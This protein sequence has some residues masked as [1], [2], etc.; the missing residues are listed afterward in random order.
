[1]QDTADEVVLPGQ[2]HIHALFLPSQRIVGMLCEAAGTH[3]NKRHAVIVQV[4][5]EEIFCT[6]KPNQAESEGAFNSK[7]D[8]NRASK[9]SMSSFSLARASL[10]CCEGQRN[11][12]QCNAVSTA[13]S[14]LKARVSFCIP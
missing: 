14:G 10:A 7:E 9:T 11:K 5:L 8:L 2:Q 6:R 1:L 12:H 4:R 3:T 13:P